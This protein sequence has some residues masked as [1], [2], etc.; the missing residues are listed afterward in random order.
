MRPKHWGGYVIVPRKLE[1]W[2]GGAFRLHDRICYTKVV[3]EK[4]VWE[5]VRLAP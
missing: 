3:G 2:Q 1:F 4:G 5:K